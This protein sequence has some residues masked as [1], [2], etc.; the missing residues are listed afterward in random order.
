MVERVG[1]RTFGI[2]YV[3][4]DTLEVLTIPVPD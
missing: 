1:R 3:N 4:V 2:T